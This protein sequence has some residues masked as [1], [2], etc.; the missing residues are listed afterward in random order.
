M[1]SVRAVCL[2]CASPLFQHE[3]GRKHRG[4]APVGVWMVA[5]QGVHG[6]HPHAPSPWS[7]QAGRATRIHPGVSRGSLPLFSLHQRQDCGDSGRLGEQSGNAQRQRS[8]L[9]GSILNGFP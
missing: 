1:L 8:F 6:P 9:N 5:G 3:L 2:L 7:F 4:A